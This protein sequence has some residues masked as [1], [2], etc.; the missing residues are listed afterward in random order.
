MMRGL[1]NKVV[2]AA[3]KTV[4]DDEGRRDD[5][6][7]QVRQDVL[8]GRDFKD[9]VRRRGVQQQQAVERRLFSGVTPPVSHKR[10]RPRPSPLTRRPKKT[11]TPRR[12]RPRREGD[13]FDEP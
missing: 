13:V 9:S 12:R 11:T 2:E 4:A 10:R 5:P 3:A 1:R 8:Q 6:A 7:G